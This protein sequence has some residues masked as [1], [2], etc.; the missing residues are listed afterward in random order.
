MCCTV[1][2]W[3]WV[4]EVRLKD[5][6][7]G[8]SLPGSL[9]D[10]L[11]KYF[12]N[13]EQLILLTGCIEHNV[14]VLGYTRETITSNILW[15]SYMMITT[16][17]KLPLLSLSRQL[18]LVYRL[19][20]ACERLHTTPPHKKR[21]IVVGKW[22]LMHWFVCTLTC[23]FSQVPA[24]CTINDSFITSL[25]WSIFRKYCFKRFCQFPNGKSGCCFGSE[26]MVKDGKLLV[27]LSK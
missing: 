6:Q 17:T 18:G 2:C 5:Q 26:N 1:V 3:I 19:W 25:I 4:H 15:W 13:L 22:P 16:L 23:Y 21:L 10:C 27:D 24:K 20:Y 9:I 14:C 11:K 7:H 12:F 8:P